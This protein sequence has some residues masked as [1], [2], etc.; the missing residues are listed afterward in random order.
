MLRHLIFENIVIFRHLLLKNKV[1]F[2]YWYGKQYWN[3]HSTPTPSLHSCPCKL[4]KQTLCEHW[5]LDWGLSKMKWQKSWLIF[6][7]SVNPAAPFYDTSLVCI[8]ISFWSTQDQVTA[9]GSLV[10]ISLSRSISIKRTSAVS[11]RSGWCDESGLLLLMWTISPH[12]TTHDDEWCVCFWLFLIYFRVFG[13]V[14]P[15][16]WVVWK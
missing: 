4:H 1:S 13:F 15:L 11:S 2:W 3:F 9:S 6:V 14:A 8:V 16:K 5:C 10:M 7:W 12:V